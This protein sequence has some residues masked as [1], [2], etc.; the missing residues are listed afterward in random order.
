[1]SA[2]VDST[3]TKQTSHLASSR[4]SLGLRGFPTACWGCPR[5]DPEGPELEST[6]PHRR[7]RQAAR[8]QGA[9]SVRFALPAVPCERSHRTPGPVAV[10][11]EVVRETKAA[12][13]TRLP[14]PRQAERWLARFQCLCG[15]S[16]RAKAPPLPACWRRTPNRCPFGHCWMRDHHSLR[17]HAPGRFAALAR[18]VPSSLGARL[19]LKL[20]ACAEAERQ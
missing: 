4:H 9:R 19:F 16:L 11:F 13:V 5:R 2:D 3:P 12:F 20:C 8:R 1:M 17:S 15:C 18:R 6:R 10:G 7:P 14:I